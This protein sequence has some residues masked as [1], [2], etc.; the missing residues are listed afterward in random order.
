M[1]RA[2]GHLLDK[3]F[4]HGSLI[5]TCRAQFAAACCSR[6]DAPVARGIA[7]LLLQLDHCH[8]LPLILRRHEDFLV[9]GCAGVPRHVLLHAALLD[10]PERVSVLPVPVHSPRQAMFPAIK[11]AAGQSGCSITEAC[12]CNVHATHTTVQQEA[13]NR[14]PVCVQSVA[15]GSTEG[16][17][18][19]V[20][21]GPARAGV[22]VRVEGQH[23]RVASDHHR[24][25]ALAATDSDLCGSGS[26]ELPSTRLRPA[27]A[28]YPWRQDGHAVHELR[29]PGGPPCSPCLTD[30]AR[31]A[32]GRSP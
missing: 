14:S 23:L 24:Y 15:H 25:P 4:T 26:I 1:L 21:E 28:A 12:T 3:S 32:H 19:R 16:P 5:C 27:T 11:V 9:L 6:S 7:A 29:Q 17:A 20:V 13:P 18:V 10:G 22:L 8:R 30:R 2:A 31:S